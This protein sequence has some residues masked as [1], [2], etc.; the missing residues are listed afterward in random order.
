MTLTGVI[1]RIEWGYYTAAAI[2]GYTVTASAAT[3]KGGAVTWRLTAT[4]ILSDPFKLTQRPLRFVAPHAKG[5]W[6]WP[7]ET[8]EFAVGA[9]QAPGRLTARLG[10]PL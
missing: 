2:E 6:T 1:G 4:V 3:T 7:I 10:M 8:L 5:T 9:G